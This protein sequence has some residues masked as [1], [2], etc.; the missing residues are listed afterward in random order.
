MRL[1]AANVFIGSGSGTPL[2]SGKYV[3]VIIADHGVGIPPE[4]LP[5]IFDPFFSTKNGGTGLGLAVVYS[6]VKNHGGQ[7]EVTSAPG[8]GTTFSLLLP[9][10]AGVASPVAPPTGTCSGRG[11]ILLMD[12][13][14]VVRQV[15]SRILTALGYEV[16]AAAEGATAVALYRDGLAGGIPFDAVI[17]DLT[18]PGGMGGAETIGL[19]LAIDP[20]VRAIVSS[21]YSSDTVMSNYGDYGFKSVIA[22]PFQ[23]NDLSRVLRQVLVESHTK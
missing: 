4:N 2:P 7:I 1:E 5:K 23:A 22:K 12:D 20:A 3:R 19:L 6:I 11:R 16:Q 13:E 8:E 14:P 17:L 18:V 15:V 9:A 10:S 21:G